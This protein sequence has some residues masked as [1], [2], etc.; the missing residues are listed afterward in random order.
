MRRTGQ[1]EGEGKCEWRET[2]ANGYEDEWQDE[3]RHLGTLLGCLRF[4]TVWQVCWDEKTR[5]RRTHLLWW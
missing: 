2:H 5:K 4:E 3:P 1:R